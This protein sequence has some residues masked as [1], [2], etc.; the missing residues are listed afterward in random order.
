MVNMYETIKYNAKP[1]HKLYL[2]SKLQ[3]ISKIRSR[4]LYADR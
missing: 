3:I 1:D 4:V 2:K